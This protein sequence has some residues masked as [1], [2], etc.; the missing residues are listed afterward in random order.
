WGYFSARRRHSAARTGARRG[1]RPGRQA[2]S[3]PPADWASVRART[4]RPPTPWPGRARRRP[5][6]VSSVDPHHARHPR[7]QLADVVEGAEGAEGVIE[8][9]PLTG[10]RLLLPRTRLR[11]VAGRDRVG[12][13]RLIDPVDG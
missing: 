1:R 8:L 10:Y 2:A 5:G 12:D 4:G 3:R 13:R 6:V 9:G 7:V 11:G